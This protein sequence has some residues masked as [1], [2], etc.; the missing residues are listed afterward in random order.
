[1][2][3]L[4]IVQ[5]LHREAKLPGTAP[6]ALTGLSGRAADLLAWSIEAWNDIQRDHDGQW[7]WLRGEFTI[8]TVADTIKYTH[9]G[10]G[11]RFRAWD[12]DLREPPLI[13][14]DAD[15]EATE[16]ELVIV[17]WQHFRRTYLRGT[18]TAAY[19]SSISADWRENLFLGPTPDAL[20]RVSGYYWKSNQTLALA[21]DEPEMPADYHM[22]IVYRALLKYAYDVVGAEILA[23]ATTFGNPL[24]NSL[25]ENQGYNRYSISLAGALA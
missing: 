17:P 22:A 4:Q 7:K 24:Y 25:V 12:L 19:P 14:L 1:M 20:Y 10:G 15:G 5:A 2:N 16:R 21:T 18:H 11:S 3:L 23:K 6:T 9:P 13:Y 8:A